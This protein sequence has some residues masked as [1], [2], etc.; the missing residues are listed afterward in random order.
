LHAPRNPSDSKRIEFDWGAPSFANPK[1]E[2]VFWAA[3]PHFTHILYI[4]ISPEPFPHEPSRPKKKG[5]KNYLKKKM[6]F[7]MIKIKGVK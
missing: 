1:K 7:P 4:L 6:G 5:F 2:A 3:S